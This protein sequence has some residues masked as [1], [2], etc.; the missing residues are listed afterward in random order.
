MAVPSLSV[1][2]P[3]H[4]T[5]ELVLS[6]VDSLRDGGVAPVDVVVVDDASNDG[7]AAAVRQ[8]H[9]RVVVIETGSNMGFGAAAN[10]GAAEASGDVILVLNSDTEVLEGGLAALE[11]AFAENPELGIA[12]AELLDPDGAPQWRAG[13]WPNR[14]WLFA[15]ASG[16]GAVAARVRGLGA[17]TG[18][19]AARTGEVD[20][21]SGAAI[22][23]RR[24]VWESCGPF[25]V[26]YRFYCQD[27]DLCRA[28]RRAGWRVAVA[29]GFAVL[30]HHG[31]TIA[32]R[33]GASGSFHP[34]HLWADLVRFA[35]KF[36]GPE[37]ARSAAAALTAGAKVRLLGRALASPFVPYRATWNR[38]SEAFREGLRTLET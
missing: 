36:D 7:T 8:R 29:V 17:G 10:L 18:S 1:V 27:L 22:A 11:A 12:G 24:D 4:D 26:G 3:T 15:Q 13:S 23:V 34:G 6:F 30:H 35:E 31:A 5:R 25:D 9:P 33:P 38:D 21:V 2:V 19:G 14:R 16:L 32:A 20:W 28:A 37:A